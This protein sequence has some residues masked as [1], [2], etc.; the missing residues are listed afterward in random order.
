MLSHLTTWVMLGRSITCERHRTFLQ[1][2][3]AN[4]DK[5]VC[6]HVVAGLL[7][8]AKRDCQVQQCDVQLPR[9]SYSYK[10]EIP[11][12]NMWQVGRCN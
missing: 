2:V 5:F 11:L 7:F 4:F 3:N 9:G 12:E 6:N 8:A 10:K 1:A